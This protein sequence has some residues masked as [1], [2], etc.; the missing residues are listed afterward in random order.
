MNIGDIVYGDGTVASSLVP[1]KTP[2][3]IVFDLENRL[4]VALTNV[5]KDGA[6]GNERLYWSNLECDVPNL[7]NCNSSAEVTYC[8]IDGRANTDAILASTCNNIEAANAVNAYE[9]SGCS[10]DFCK[11]TKWFLP[12]MRDLNTLYNRKSIVG[13]TLDLLYNIGAVGFKEW[14]WS[15]TEKNSS[16]AWRMNLSEGRADEAHKRPA[17]FNYQFVRPVLAF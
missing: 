7:R 17:G 13:T 1:G 6:A 14:Y 5:K 12:S 10:K 4:A 9:P 2:I 15:S 11:K 16:D 3:G 8:G